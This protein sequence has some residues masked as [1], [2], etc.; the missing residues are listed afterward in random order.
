MYFDKFDIVAAYYCYYVDYHSG[1]FSREYER[2][3]KIQSYFTPSPM[4][5]GYKSLSD[6]AQAIYDSLVEKNN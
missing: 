4:F 2:L 5:N 3:S 1:Q 6:N